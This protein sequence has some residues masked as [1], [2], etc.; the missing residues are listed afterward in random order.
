VW[1]SRGEGIAVLSAVSMKRNKHR[2]ARRSVEAWPRGVP[3]KWYRI[4]RP[5]F[6]SGTK[7][8]KQT[9]GDARSKK[10]RGGPVR[11]HPSTG[12]GVRGC[13]DFYKLTEDPTL[14]SEK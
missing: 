12:N 14:M 7:V 3:S 11:E 1:S 8:K 5:G 9:E 10:R 2:S 4:K 13:P 6:K